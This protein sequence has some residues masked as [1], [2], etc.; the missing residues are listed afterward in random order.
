MRYLVGVAGVLIIYYGLKIIFPE[1]ESILAYLL[2]YLRYT[3]IGF[4]VS[5]GAP[6]IFIRLRL[7]EKLT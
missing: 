6:W 1:G 5:A 7:A 3:L 4:W 2:R